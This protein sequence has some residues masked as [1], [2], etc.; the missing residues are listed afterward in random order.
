MHNLI[1]ENIHQQGTGFLIMGET[2]TMNAAHSSFANG[3]LM[4]VD[5]N[6]QIVNN[7]TGDCQPVN[8]NFSASPGSIQEPLLEHR[9]ANDISGTSWKPFDI[10][11]QDIEVHPTSYCTQK[12]S[13][14]GA[15]TLKQR[16]DGCSINDTLVFFLQDAETMGAS[17]TWQYDNQYFHS[18]FS[19][20][21]SILLQPVRAGRSVVKATVEGNCYLN[22]QQINT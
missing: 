6:G 8:R 9:Q 10:I 19:N 7:G 5:G 22:N 1:P 16:G 17:A 20:G 4:K 14:G 3:F 15:V 21:D 11:S 12:G 2:D 13:G 18:I